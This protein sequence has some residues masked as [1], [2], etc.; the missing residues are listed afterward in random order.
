MRSHL[1]PIIP[2]VQFGEEKWNLTKGNVEILKEIERW[3]LQWERIL[4]KSKP[5]FY[6]TTLTQNDNF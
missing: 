1:V 4:L 3:Q 5:R 2:R 6:A